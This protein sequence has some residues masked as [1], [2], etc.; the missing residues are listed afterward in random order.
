MTEFEKL[1]P[2]K[3]INQVKKLF[4]S[5][6]SLTL[7]SDE[8]LTRILLDPEIVRTLLDSEVGIHSS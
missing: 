5:I 4:I 3:A 2:V 6:G 8:T 7:E 1:K